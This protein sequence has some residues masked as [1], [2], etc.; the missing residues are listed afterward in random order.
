MTVIHQLRR[1]SEEIDK[2][3]AAEIRGLL[4][5]KEG[6]LTSGASPR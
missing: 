3:K 5:D 2:L 4:K 1:N 6:T